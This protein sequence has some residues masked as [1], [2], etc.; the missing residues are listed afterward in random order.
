MPDDLRDP[1]RAAANYIA[2]SL[3]RRS[4]SSRIGGQ[5]R[6]VGRSNG[7]VHLVN[8]D[9]AAYMTQTNRRHMTFGRRRDPWHHE[10]ERTPNRTDWAGRAVDSAIDVAVNR[11]GDEY[12]RELRIDL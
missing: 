5:W 2:A 4:P 9:I 3:R 7:S 11:L 6:I 12:M 1:L 8:D 10:N